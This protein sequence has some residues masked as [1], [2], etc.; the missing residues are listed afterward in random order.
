M[1][2][3]TK[4]LQYVFRVKRIRTP[5]TA[6]VSFLFTRPI[7]TG[8]IFNEQIESQRVPGNEHLH[9]HARSLESIASGG[10]FRLLPV[11]FCL[12][13]DIWIGSLAGNRWK[14]DG[15]P[16]KVAVS[17][18][19]HPKLRRRQEDDQTENRRHA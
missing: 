16:W 1:R 3:P 15:S 8:N 12:A 5:R 6:N 11:A 9:T 18:I 7:S 10:Y 19:R 17:R 2:M 13:W 14:E 4:E